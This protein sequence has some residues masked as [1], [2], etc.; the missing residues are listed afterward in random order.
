VT[1][2]SQTGASVPL[3]TQPEQC[4]GHLQQAG[5]DLGEVEVGAHLLGVDVELLA[6]HQLAVVGGVGTG[7]WPAVG[8]VAARA[9]LEKGEVATAGR[10]GQRAIRSMKS[11]IAAALA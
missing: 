6:A 9:L 7:Q 11:A 5:P 3:R 4:A 10:L 8:V 1:A 2:G